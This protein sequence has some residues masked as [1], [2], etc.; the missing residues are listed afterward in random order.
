MTHDEFLNGV[1]FMESRWGQLHRGFEDVG[2]VYGDFAAFSADVM[3]EAIKDL[4]FDGR[5][6]CPSPSTVIHRMRDKTAVKH[7]AAPQTPPEHCVTHRWAWEPGP[8]NTRM[9]M[10]VLCGTEQ[11]FSE[12]GLRTPGEL[13]AGPPP[14]EA[15]E[16]EVF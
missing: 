11:T 14:R 12:A 8:Q 5:Q 13:E 10:C 2:A 9:A 15:P 16:Q 4:Y 1:E 6:G 7:I 3:N